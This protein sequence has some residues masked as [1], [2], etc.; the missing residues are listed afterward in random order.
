MLF[1][2]ALSDSRMRLG[3]VKFGSLEP[4]YGINLNEL[5]LYTQDPA[6]YNRYGVG[7]YRLIGTR[8]LKSIYLRYHQFHFLH[9]EI[10][11]SKLRPIE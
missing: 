4:I 6:F 10:T 11:L 8:Q 1:D 5:I 7:N 9:S 2:E 3:E